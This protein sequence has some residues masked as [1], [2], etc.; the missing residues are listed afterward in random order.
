MHAKPGRR[1]C[2]RAEDCGV[3]RDPHPTQFFRWRMRTVLSVP[4]GRKWYFSDEERCETGE[5][6]RWSDDNGWNLIQDK[7]WLLSHGVY[8]HGPTRQSW[9][10]ELY[11]RESAISKSA[12]ATVGR[13]RNFPMDFGACSFQLLWDASPQMWATKHVYRGNLG[14]IVTRTPARTHI[15]TQMKIVYTLIY[16][17]YIL[18][19]TSLL[20]LIFEGCCLHT[21][22][23]TSRDTSNLKGSTVLSIQKLG[24][25]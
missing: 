4:T 17:N 18:F 19:Q 10:H 22:A 25:L 7:L 21:R 9:I 11:S 5:D 3:P 8:V 2:I 20:S 12:R 14:T 15:Y 16:T 23:F 1:G 6:T 24:V 13:K